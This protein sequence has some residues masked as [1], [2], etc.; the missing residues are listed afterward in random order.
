MLPIL[1]DTRESVMGFLDMLY[2]PLGR[3]APFSTCLAVI[4]LRRE[5]DIFLGWHGWLQASHKNRQ[6]H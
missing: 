6:D 5:R 3:L 2:K 4:R 1:I